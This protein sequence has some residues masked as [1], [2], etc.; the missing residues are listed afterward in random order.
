MI[1][2]ITL[3]KFET[4]LKM[5]NVQNI[6]SKHMFRKDQQYIWT[7]SYISYTSKSQYVAKSKYTHSPLIV[8]TS[9]D[10]SS[11]WFEI[12]LL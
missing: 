3:V 10:T 4:N 6:Y 12:L 9:S 1:I 7:V 11:D 8:N 5:D 2:V